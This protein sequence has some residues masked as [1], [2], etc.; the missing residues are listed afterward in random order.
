[1]AW[2]GYCRRHR[3]RLVYVLEDRAEDL[4]AEARAV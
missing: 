4:L 2:S 3:L 1:M